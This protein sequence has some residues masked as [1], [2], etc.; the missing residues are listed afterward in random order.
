MTELSHYTVLTWVRAYE[1]AWR[2]GDID[3]VARLFTED[4]RYRRSPYEPAEVGHDAVRAF[5]AEDAGHVF[6]VEAHPVA[7]EG[8]V[9][10]VR[11][12]VRYTAPEQQEY[13]DLWLLRFAADGRV[14]DFEEW[15]YW[16]GRGYTAGAD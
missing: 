7:V 15:A 10:V 6:T 1:D 9:A 4:V 5:W 3:A 12:L 8:P 13:S 2:S 11:L 16:P 14:A